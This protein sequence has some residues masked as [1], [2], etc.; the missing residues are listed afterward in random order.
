M[1]AEKV[2]ETFEAPNDKKLGWK[3]VLSLA[4]SFVASILIVIVALYADLIDRVMTL[5]ASMAFYYPITSGFFIF[6]VILFFIYK[7]VKK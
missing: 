7:K 3:T 4:F 2:Y 1:K 5:F 6:G